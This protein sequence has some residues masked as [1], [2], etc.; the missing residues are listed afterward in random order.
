MECRIN[1]QNPIASGGRCRSLTEAA[2]LYKQ[3]DIE[4]FW[5][6]R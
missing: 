5:V 1:R 4:S 6:I 2:E 3:F